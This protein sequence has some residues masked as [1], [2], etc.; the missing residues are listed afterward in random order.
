MLVVVGDALTWTDSVG[1]SGGP[2]AG[3]DALGQL[4]DVG[5]DIVLASD[6][7]VGQAGADLGDV[8][9]TPFAGR[10]IETEAGVH[11]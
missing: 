4:D 6:G 8:A 5:V 3:A 10:G 1:R 11:P 7:T 2:L 9:E